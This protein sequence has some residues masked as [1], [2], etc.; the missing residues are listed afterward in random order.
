MLAQTRGLLLA[1]V[2]GAGLIG[3]WTDDAESFG[4]A[5][6]VAADS[7]ATSPADAIHP[8]RADDEPVFQSTSRDRKSVSITVYNQNFG[9]AR[10][11]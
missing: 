11:P 1:A 5:A 6:G 4:A 2:F 7:A 3:G 8:A 10:G 9:L